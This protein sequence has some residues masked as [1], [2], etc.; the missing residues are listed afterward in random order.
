MAPISIRG[1][2]PEPPASGGLTSSRPAGGHRPRSRDRLVQSSATGKPRAA[3]TARPVH[4]QC[5]SRRPESLRANSSP[6][7]SASSD[8]GCSHSGR[9]L[10]R[11]G[12][13]PTG[14][15]RC[16]TPGPKEESPLLAL[17]LSLLHS[18]AASATVRVA[19]A[20]AARLGA[21][22][23]RQFGLP[24]AAAPRPG[25]NN[26]AGQDRKE[27]LIRP[28][29]FFYYSNPD[30][31]CKFRP[32]QLSDRSSKNA[33]KRLRPS[34]RSRRRSGR[35]SSGGRARPRACRTPVPPPPRRR[36]SRGPPAS[37]RRGSVPATGCGS[38][39]S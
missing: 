24:V 30:V 3:L 31:H 37:R 10:G 20:L 7:P 9:T 16:G 5:Q 4:C 25:T 18:Q 39:S 1:Q 22:L 32:L 2:E 21:G 11:R 14:K 27:D 29:C 17:S 6:V 36:R 12:S 15:P 8:A 19:V 13:R 26:T 35:S 23:S 38:C 34:S 33:P 28:T